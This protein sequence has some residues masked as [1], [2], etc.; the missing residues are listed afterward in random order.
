MKKSSVKKLSLNKDT[1]RSLT[2]DL[3]ALKLKEVVGN[4]YTFLAGCSLRVTCAC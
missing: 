3:N 2:Q 1:L 4:G